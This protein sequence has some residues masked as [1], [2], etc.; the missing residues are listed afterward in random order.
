MRLKTII[1]LISILSTSTSS[2]SIANSNEVYAI[3]ELVSFTFTPGE[4]ELTAPSTNVKFELVVNH[5]IGIENSKVGVSLSSAKNN[6]LSLE[7]V[8]TRNCANE[9]LSKSNFTFF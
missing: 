3:P 5:P 6:N 1:V 2:M 8:S 4:I 9:Y 7:L